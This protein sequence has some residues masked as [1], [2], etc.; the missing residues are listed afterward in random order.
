VSIT[1]LAEAIIF[2]SIED[3][4]STPEKNRPGS[5]RLCSVCGYV[6]KANRTAQADRP[7]YSDRTF[8]LKCGA[9]STPL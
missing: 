5:L 8:S 6:D 4:W 1:F 2:Q 7:P 3:L 9:N